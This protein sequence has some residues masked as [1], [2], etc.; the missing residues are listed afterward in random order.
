MKKGVIFFLLA[1]SVLMIRSEYG[2]RKQVCMEFLWDGLWEEL[3]K[4]FSC[5]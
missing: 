2:E 4:N 1:L 5:E 3:I